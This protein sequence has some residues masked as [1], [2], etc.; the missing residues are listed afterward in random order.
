MK[1][2]FAYKIAGNVNGKD[3]IVATMQT[4][5]DKEMVMKYKEMLKD[6]FGEEIH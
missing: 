3:V 2:K 5:E 4:Y 6:L 1:V